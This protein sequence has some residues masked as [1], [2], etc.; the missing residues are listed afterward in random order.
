MHNKKM[1]QYPDACS[2]FDQEEVSDHVK[3]SPR[4]NLGLPK[5]KI[6]TSFRRK[7]FNTNKEKKIIYDKHI[8]ILSNCKFGMFHLS[9]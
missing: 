7:N 4:S 3:T 2:W 9:V 6:C 5:S 8:I 1:C